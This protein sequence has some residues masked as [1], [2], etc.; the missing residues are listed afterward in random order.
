VY[1]QVE[2]KEPWCAGAQHVV[3]IGVLTPE[4]FDPALWRAEVDFRPIRGMTRMLQEGAHQ[5]DIIDSSADLA[6]Y[7]VVVLPDETRSPTRSRT[8]SR[9]T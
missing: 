6:A 2:E 5:F 1:A 7:K 3:D 4:E 8:S 9:A